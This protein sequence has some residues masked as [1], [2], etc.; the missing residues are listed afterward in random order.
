MSDLFLVGF[1]G[2]RKEYYY[3]SFHHSLNKGDYVI[4]QV[5]RGEDCGEVLQQVEKEITIPDGEKPSSILRRANE[6]DMARLDDN[7]KEEETAWETGLR[8]IKKHNL[9]MKLVDIEYQLDRNKITFFFTADHR[10]DFRALVRDLASEYKTRIELRQIGVRDEARRIGGFGVCGIEQCCVSFLRKFDPISTQD[11]RIQ[12]LSL[13][14]SKISGNC[15]R[16]LC[17]LK[18]EVD[19]YDEVLRKY[20]EIGAKYSAGGINGIVENV[21][22]F[23]DCMIVRTSEGEEIR[24][25]GK[26]IVQQGPMRART[27]ELPDLSEVEEDYEGEGVSEDY[28]GSEKG[29]ADGKEDG[30]REE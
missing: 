18:Y 24:V 5:D 9:G 8:L 21:S 29:T 15:G 11:A 4:V 2:N 23:E 30:K 12:N 3:N 10:V 7:R 1:K 25:S 28:N 22:A 6:D 26:D 13:N 27:A 19:F 16:L 20:P 17:C 14:P